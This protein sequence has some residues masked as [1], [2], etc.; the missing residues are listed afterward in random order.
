M[1]FFNTNLKTRILIKINKD[2]LKL[3]QFYSSLTTSKC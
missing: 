2:K 1:E 3:K